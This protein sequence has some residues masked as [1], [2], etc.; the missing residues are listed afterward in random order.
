MGFWIGGSRN[1]DL[2]P[3]IISWKNKNE[4]IKILG[5]YFNPLREASNIDLNWISKIDKAKSIIKQLEKR[6]I[7]VFGRILLCKTYVQS[8]FAYALQSLSLPKKVIE[9]IDSMCFKS[10][11][12]SNSNSK[13]VIEKV[14]RSVMCLELERGG[15]NM[16]KIAD[17]Q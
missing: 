6:K 8:L 9:E 16:I 2:V 4:F 3:Q 12:K 13:M 5:V 7:S 1:N 17:H 15:A 14:R 11:W 10:I